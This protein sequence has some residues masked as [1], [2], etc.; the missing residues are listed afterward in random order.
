M[1]IATNNGVPIIRSGSI[2][3]TCT[4]CGWSCYAP[5]AGACCD[6]TNCRVVQQCDCDTENGEVFKGIGTTCE[7]NPCV[8][9]CCQVNGNCEDGITAAECAERNGYGFAAG[10]T[11][12]SNPCP[13][14]CCTG[15]SRIPSSVSL[16]VV[17][18]SVSRTDQLGR[19]IGP[20]PAELIDEIW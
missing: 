17:T 3:T 2:V 9:R 6:G 5:D 18:G 11:C 19:A 13:I 14:P 15:E 16:R 8:G 10:T 4:C 20:Y 7:P 1:S 12:I